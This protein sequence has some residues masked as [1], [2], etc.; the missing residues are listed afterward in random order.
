[1]T[2]G[3]HLADRQCVV[4]ADEGIDQKFCG[5]FIYLYRNGTIEVQAEGDGKG[6]TVRA[7]C[8]LV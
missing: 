4:E 6:G 8:T 1:V 3:A 2:E 7:G 5:N